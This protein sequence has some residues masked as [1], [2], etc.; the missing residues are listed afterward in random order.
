MGAGL[1]SRRA[2][3]TAG[4]ALASETGFR[5]AADNAGPRWSIA[6]SDGYSFDIIQDIGGGFPTRDAA[7][8]GVIRHLERNHQE[9]T[10]SLKRARRM[11]SYRRSVATRQAGARA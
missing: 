1:V 6:L 3:V 2:L 5:R 11:R 10:R 4:L 8:D 7:I 9:L